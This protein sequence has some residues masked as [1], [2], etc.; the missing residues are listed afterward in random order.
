[1]TYAR[2]ARRSDLP[3]GRLISAEFLL[4]ESFDHRR[5]TALRHS[6]AACAAAAGLTGNR[7]DDFVVAVNELLT[8]VVRHG[9]GAG[10]MT[11]W[12]DGGSVICEV[13]DRG[14]GI[15]RARPVKM[16]RPAANQPGGWGLWLAAE[17]TDAMT[18]ETGPD[19]TTVRISTRVT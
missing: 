11:M 14:P 17:L 10:R 8:N 9:G 12:S 5:V 3:Y 19:G 7:L 6:V 4:S 2:P 1:M 18:L 13:V 15:D 16:Q